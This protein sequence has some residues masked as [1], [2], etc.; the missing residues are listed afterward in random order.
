M[1][2]LMRLIFFLF[3]SIFE[4]SMIFIYDNNNDV[5]IFATSHNIK[6]KL[7]GRKKREIFFR[8]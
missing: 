2:K 6:Y 7:N 8:E 5:A 1:K 4:N 3:L